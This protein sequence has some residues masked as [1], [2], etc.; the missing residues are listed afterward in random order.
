MRQTTICFFAAAAAFL[1]AAAPP[2]ADRLA[3]GLWEESTRITGATLAGLPA[4]L[5]LPAPSVRR[6]CVPPAADVAMVLAAERADCTTDRA[7][8]GAGR[9]SLSGVCQARNGAVAT[10]ET[11]GRYA[12]DGY[13]LRTATTLV[14]SARPLVVSS[15]ITARRIGVCAA[16]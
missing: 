16:G 10:T 15:E 9:V 1:T 5:P 3:P 6:L 4:P 11:E 14:Q 13:T 7:R 2:P 12:A 8:V